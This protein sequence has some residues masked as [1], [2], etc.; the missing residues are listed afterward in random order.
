VNSRSLAHRIDANIAQMSTLID[1]LARQCQ[2]IKRDILD[3][4]RQA[5]RYATSHFISDDTAQRLREKKKELSALESSLRRARSTGRPLRVVLKVNRPTRV[6]EEELD[7]EDWD[8]IE[9]DLVVEK[10]EK[11]MIWLQLIE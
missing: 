10:T 9:E 1:E 8:E 2:A 4:L 7:E 6:V 3:T 5:A 11:R